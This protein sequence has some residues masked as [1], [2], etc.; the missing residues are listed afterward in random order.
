MTVA[1][2]DSAAAR[3]LRIL[4]FRW[5]LGA[6]VAAALWS[7][8][9]ILLQG[10]FSNS[11]GAL[12]AGVARL[13]ILVVLPVVVLGFVWGLSERYRLERAIGNDGSIVDR[14]L[15]TAVWR[16]IGKAIVCG[17]AFGLLTCGLGRFRALH[18]W[19]SADNI[20]AN[21]LGVLA[22]AVVAAP[23]GLIVGISVRRNLSRRL[24][25]DAVH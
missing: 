4:P 16:N 20:E 5:T 2:A 6:L 10:G 21:V 25:E 14:L 8:L 12:L 17:V 15:R 19:D 1:Q 7:L 18:P 3:W 9:S 11:A 23:I 24:N 22:F 13:L